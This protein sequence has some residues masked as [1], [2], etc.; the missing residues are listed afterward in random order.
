MKSGIELIAEERAEQSSKYG[1]SAEH[2]LT[3]NSGELAVEAAGLA[4]LHTDTVVVQI[5]YEAGSIFNQEKRIAD[6]WGLQ[7]KLKDNPIHALKVAGAL[8][9][10]EIDRLQHL[11]S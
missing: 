9:A 7:K 1:W 2:D 11:N 3:H 10:A 4:V 6:A 5:N 8:I